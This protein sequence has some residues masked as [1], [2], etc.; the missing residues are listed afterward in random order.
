MS[1]AS[2][3]RR[4]APTNALGFTLLETLVVIAILAILIG[5][6]L[7]AIQKVRV[8]AN[9]M[10]A[11]NN[12]KQMGLAT[13]HFSA[14][15]MDD[16][17]WMSVVLQPPSKACYTTYVQLM[18]YL[19][20]ASLY[21]AIMANEFFRGSATV[22][23]NPLDPDA[24]NVQKNEWARVSFAAN[25]RVFSPASR[26]PAPALF[27][28]G[29]SNTILFAET[30]LDCREKYRIWSYEWPTFRFG[31][32]LQRATFAD[33]DLVTVTARCQDYYP[34]TTGNPPVSRASVPHVTFQVRPTTE[35]CDPRV[36][37]GQSPGGLIVGFADG[38]VRVFSP[39]ID[40]TIF[41]G[42]VTPDMGEVIVL[43]N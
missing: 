35:A 23:L 5:L 1:T 41:W 33:N 22:F 9:A 43:D 34:I 15:H 10:K 31:H 24:A 25:A 30:K 14:D 20:Y 2:C 39:G 37:N 18:P 6:L 17:P 13:T 40:P 19:E 7:P 11:K 27:T 12:L 4:Q 29:F 26:C 28:D 42:A 21:R 36:P 8:A 32:F 3:K 16:M 38:S